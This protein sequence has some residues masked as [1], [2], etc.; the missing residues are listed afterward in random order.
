M[1]EQDRISLNASISLLSDGIKTARESELLSEGSYNDY[2]NKTV[3]K[4]YESMKET[5][6]EDFIMPAVEGIIRGVD[7]AFGVDDDVPI[8]NKK[9]MEETDSSQ[10]T[11]LEPRQTADYIQLANQ[12]VLEPEKVIDSLADRGEDS[13]GMFETAAKEGSVSVPVTKEVRKAVKTARN[14]IGKASSS[15]AKSFGYGS[16]KLVSPEVR[17]QNIEQLKT[18]LVNAVNLYKSIDP[19]QGRAKTLITPAGGKSERMVIKNLL[20]T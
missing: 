4:T 14:D 1:S 9:I 18:A 17:S 5:Y 20:I 2:I 6:G 12:G 11:I 13:L 10:E 8:G 7:P 15:V 19:Q 3:K 16:N